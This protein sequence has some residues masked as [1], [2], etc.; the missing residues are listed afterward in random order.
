[1]APNTAL[2]PF[3]TTL[4]QTLHLI[5]WR[6]AHRPQV[7]ESRRLEAARR[8]AYQ[9]VH[10]LRLETFGAPADRRREAAW[11]YELHVALRPGG[12]RRMEASGHE[13]DC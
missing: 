12:L 6:T 9:V 1:M 5:R 7:R 11:L 13:R 10:R 2:I 4:P 8:Q 3:Y